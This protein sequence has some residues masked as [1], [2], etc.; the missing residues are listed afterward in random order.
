MDTFTTLQGVTD[1]QETRRGVELIAGNE[2]VRVEFVKV[3]ILRI[4]ISRDG[5]FDAS[6]TF[7]VVKDEF[8]NPDFTA[9]KTSRGLV[10]KT[11]QLTVRISFD[12]FHFD[13]LRAD[14]SAVLKSARNHAYA[15]KEGEWRVRRTKTAQ[16]TILGLG[17]K[18]Q[19]FNHNGRRLTM[20]NTDVLAPATDGA[21]RVQDDPD[22][23]HNPTNDHFDP[24]YISIN[25]HYHLPHQHPDR[26]AASFIDCGYKLNYDF[27]RS[28]TYEIHGEGGQLTEYVFA[29]PSIKQI[30]QQYT[31]LT[32]RMDPPPL[33]S[34][35]HHQCRWHEYEERDVN[36]LAHTYRRKKLP[37]DTLWLDIDYMDEYRVF[38]WNEE[39]FPRHAAM[40][41]KLKQ[42]G[43]RVIT[44]IDPGVKEEPGYSIF[45][46]GC[47]HNFFCKTESGEI[48]VGQV[49]PGDTVFP[50]FVKEET[51]RWWGRLNAEHVRSGLAGIWND[52]NEPS[53]GVVPPFAMRFDRDGANH[54]HERYRNQYALLMAM[55]TVMGLREA[56]PELRT[57]ILSR[58]GFAG[59]QRYAA[60]WTGDNCA[61]WKHLA[62]SIPMNA[63]LGL[64]GQPFVGSDIGGFLGEASAELLVRWYQY[65]VFQPFMRNHLCKGSPEH[66]PWSFGADIEE[67]IR[68]ALE[69]RYQL[70]PYLYSAFIQSAETGSPIQRPLVYEWQ[71]DPEAVANTSEFMFG[72]HLLVAPVITEGETRRTLYLPA[73]HWQ[74]FY[75]GDHVE[76]GRSIKV[77]APL[78]HLPLFVRSGAVIPTIQAVQTTDGL[79]PETVELHIY[80]PQHDGT[81][82][83][84]LHEDDGLT[85]ACRHGAFV[86]TAF[87][88]TRKGEQFT[89]TAKCT[90]NGFLEFRRRE[91]Q[92]IFHGAKLGTST[93]TNAGTPFQRSFTL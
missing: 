53:T 86:R 80:V 20:W 32:G 12:P 16:D 56:M 11:S 89:L 29:G 50:D 7:A 72:D 14:G 88:L 76:G 25:L 17:E 47:E 22:S 81:T 54:P 5:A 34:L 28:R 65:G 62:M 57:F 79:A 30:V 63:N 66:Y 38:T 67:H 31:E 27:T 74:C 2:R 10:L 58:A 48:Y 45:D 83:S 59:I 55:G 18:T 33:W 15:F 19:P 21:V 71:A 68:K 35:G 49:W 70:L 51:R 61:D 42:D 26:A 1:W 75:T 93:I 60:N 69:L 23:P 44:I 92:L 3:D 87:T 39:K 36:K 37:C 13:I 24:Y 84:M 77:D 40:L 6:P 85:D 4:K 41:E 78:G 43:F 46:E 90:G 73:G 64:S 8:G 82:L 9:R 91:F 52:M